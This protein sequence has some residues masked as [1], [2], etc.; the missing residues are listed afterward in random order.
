MSTLSI[1]IMVIL[2][3]IAM[4]MMSSGWE[5][6]ILFIFSLQER[7]SHKEHW[8]DE[9]HLH[10]GGEGGDNSLVKIYEELMIM[11]FFRGL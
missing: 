4:C 2:W 1:L 11:G 3:I 8:N 7:S 6:P 9:S 10:T 5:Q